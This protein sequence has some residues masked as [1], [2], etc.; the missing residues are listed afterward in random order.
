MQQRDKSKLDAFDALQKKIDPVKHCDMID[1][2]VNLIEF[3]TYMDS[4]IDW[5]ALIRIESNQYNL[6]YQETLDI[7][8]YCAY[9]TNHI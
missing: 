1:T 9:V 5:E 3:K 2:C 4:P 7:V 8:K 6:S